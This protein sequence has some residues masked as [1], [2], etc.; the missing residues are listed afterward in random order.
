VTKFIAPICIG[1]RFVVQV[2]VMCLSCM[3]FHISTTMN[4]HNVQY[5]VL[6]VTLVDLIGLHENLH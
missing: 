6:L 5:S 3:K 1:S 2:R 4:I